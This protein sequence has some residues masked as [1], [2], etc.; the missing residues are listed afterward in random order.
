MNYFRNKKKNIFKNTN[1][2]CASTPLTLNLV[3][4]DIAIWKCFS[5]ICCS[6]VTEIGQHWTKTVL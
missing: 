5:S 3:S 1:S 2:T 4:M 6:C